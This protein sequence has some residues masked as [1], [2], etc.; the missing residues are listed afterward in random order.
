MGLEGMC[1]YCDK[2]KDPFISSSAMLRHDEKECHVPLGLLNV[3]QCHS[4]MKGHSVVP[5]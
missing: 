4:P 1:P 2:A 3:P 5:A